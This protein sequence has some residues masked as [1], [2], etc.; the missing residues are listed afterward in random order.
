MIGWPAVPCQKT[1]QAN[2]HQPA[3]AISEETTSRRV[4][5]ASLSPSSVT[6]DEATALAARRCQVSLK[7]LAESVLWRLDTSANGLVAPATR[8]IPELAHSSSEIGP[9]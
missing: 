2:P 6:V 8:S 9:L 7:L 5:R 1:N 3:T 4:I